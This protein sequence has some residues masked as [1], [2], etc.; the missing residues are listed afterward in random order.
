MMRELLKTLQERLEHYTREHDREKNSDMKIW[1]AGYCRAL[2]TVI[3]DI[4]ILMQ[5][6]DRS[7]QGNDGN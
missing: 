1:L 3:N 5:S 4:Q 7:E 2:N 6:N